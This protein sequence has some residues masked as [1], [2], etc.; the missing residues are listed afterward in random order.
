LKLLINCLLAL[1][2]FVSLGA[3]ARNTGE[4][5][6]RPLLPVHVNPTWQKE[7]SNCHIAYPPGLLPADSWRKIMTG[8]DKH[9]GADASLTPQETAEITSFLVANPSNRWTAKTAPLRITE[10]SW[11]KS[12]HSEIRSAIWT[13]AAVKSRSNCSACHANAAKGDFN[14]RGVRIPK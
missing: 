8:L 13:R 4:E 9:F 2:A 6:G 14:E 12:K 7:C 5:R 3:Q 11:Y 1:L 10:S